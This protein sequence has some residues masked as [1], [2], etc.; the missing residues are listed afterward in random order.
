MGRGTRAFRSNG[1]PG[2]ALPNRGDCKLVLAERVGAVSERH[3]WVRYNDWDDAGGTKKSEK[4][5]RNQG[6]KY[7]WGRSQAL[8]K[9]PNPGLV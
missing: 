7:D 4:S 9:T 6:T 8:S 5:I 1:L 2:L 3:V